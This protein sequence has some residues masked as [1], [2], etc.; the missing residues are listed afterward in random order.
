MSKQGGGKGEGKAIKRGRDAKTGQFI[1]VNE[2]E[3]RPR[4]TVVETIKQTGKGKQ[5][6]AAKCVQHQKPPKKK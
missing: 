2:A 1:P 3:R 5:V 6:I 4:T